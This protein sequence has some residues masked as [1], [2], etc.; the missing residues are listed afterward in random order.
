LPQRVLWEGA[1]FWFF[2]HPTS[3]TGSEAP[4]RPVSSIKGKSRP[5]PEGRSKQTQ[6][7]SLK[8][9]EKFKKQKEKKLKQRTKSKE[10]I[11]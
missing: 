4:S 1:Y 2:F 11:H 10:Y 6:R 5:E 3:C 7:L 9:V 8:E